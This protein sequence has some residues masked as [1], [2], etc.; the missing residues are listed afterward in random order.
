MKPETA[1]NILGVVVCL[2]VIAGL[3]MIMGPVVGH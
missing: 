2:A 3:M 1:G